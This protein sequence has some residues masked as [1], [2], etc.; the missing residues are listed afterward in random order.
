MTTMN[1]DSTMGHVGRDMGRRWSTPKHTT[2]RW[3]S[4]WS[5]LA[6]PV[7]I[8][9]T[10][11]GLG[12]R[13]SGQVFV[14]VTPGARAWLASLFPQPSQECGSPSVYDGDSTGGD[15]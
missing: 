8:E 12:N 11:C 3:P 14:Q 6:P 13:W 10:T 2:I 7:G 15:A 1:R 5:F 9:P 4:T